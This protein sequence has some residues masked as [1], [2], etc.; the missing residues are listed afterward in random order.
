[1]FA[2]SLLLAACATPS[3]PQPL[4]YRFSM[5]AFTDERSSEELAL[6]QTFPFS[7]AMFFNQLRKV[8]PYSI[9]GSAEAAL[10]VAMTHYEATRYGDSYAVSMVMEMRGRDAYARG[11]LKKPFMCSAVA[12]R[13][14]ELDDYAQQVWTDKNLTALTPAAREEKMWHQVFSTCVRDLADQFG[15]A[16]VAAQTAKG[17][18]R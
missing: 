14:F 11:L 7:Q 12:H 17:A 1:M 6:P 5:G 9:F 3:A 8:M 18:I 13:G 16:L 10:D 2:A 15:S 4:P